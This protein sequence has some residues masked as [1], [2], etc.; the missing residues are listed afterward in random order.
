MSLRVS[1]RVCS[2][3]ETGQCV[4][5][6][7]AWGA[8]E[9]YLS[10]SSQSRHAPRSAMTNISTA[11]AQTGAEPWWHRHTRAHFIQSHFNT[12]LQSNSFLCFSVHLSPDVKHIR[13]STL[14]SSSQQLRKPHLFCLFV[15]VDGACVVIWR[16]AIG[17]RSA[18][19]LA[20]RA[21]TTSNVLFHLFSSLIHPLFPPC[22]IET[23]LL[24]SHVWK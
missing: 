17:P 3:E 11:L 6:R 10:F 21:P 12:H 8:R 16:C 19:F 4:F 5:T 18:P 9:H 2:V 15:W 13:A 22:L 20:S 24:F 1:R 23:A 14:R 7:R